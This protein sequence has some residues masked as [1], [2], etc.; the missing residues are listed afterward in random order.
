[1]PMEE[2]YRRRLPRNVITG[3]V[4]NLTDTSRD[5]RND[6][7][8]EINDFSQRLSLV[9]YSPRFLANDEVIISEQQLHL[10]IINTKET[11]RLSTYKWSGLSKAF[12]SLMNWLALQSAL[13]CTPISTLIWSLYVILKLLKTDC[14]YSFFWCIEPFLDLLTA[15]LSLEWKFPIPLVLIRFAVFDVLWCKYFGT[16][17]KQFLWVFLYISWYT[18]YNFRSWLLCKGLLNSLPQSWSWTY[19]TGAQNN[20]MILN[21]ETRFQLWAK[22]RR[23]SFQFWKNR[24][25]LSIK[26]V[27]STF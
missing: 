3:K 21:I 16:D 4:E 22:Y 26:G 25:M 12:L 8:Y 6:V 18:Q 13:N 7:M 17:I 24:C 15:T 10:P 2:R 11:L 20:N 19:R 1:M 23:V 14:V 5:V 27:F 9:E